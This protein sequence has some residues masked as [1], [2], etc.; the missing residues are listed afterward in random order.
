[1][2]RRANAK[3]NALYQEMDDE[4]I[5]PNFKIPYRKELLSEQPAV[6]NQFWVKDRYNMNQFDEEKIMSE[7]DKVGQRICGQGSKCMDILNNDYFDIL[8]SVV[9][10]IDTMSGKV[11]KKVIELLQM[12][13]VKLK[14]YI[15]I[16]K[17]QEY[18]KQNV[19]TSHN[20]QN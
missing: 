6:P 17:M 9:Y 13:L 10:Y 20:A 19:I 12:G 18:S 11:K 14:H 2:S 8:Y 5:V 4:K 16:R 1:M 7:L 3:I 15:D